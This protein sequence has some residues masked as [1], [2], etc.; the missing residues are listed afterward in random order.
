MGNP[1]RLPLDVEPTV[2]KFSV[3]I[4]AQN[5]YLATYNSFAELENKL[6]KHIDTFVAEKL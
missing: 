4:V 1:L 5:Q 6:K 2:R 3:N